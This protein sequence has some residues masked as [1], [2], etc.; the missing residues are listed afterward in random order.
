MT[1]ANLTMSQTANAMKE[2]QEQM[3]AARKDLA[4]QV[5]A[6][7]KTVLDLTTKAAI[8]SDVDEF[9]TPNSNYL[10]AVA[11]SAVWRALR[12]QLVSA[13]VRNEAVQADRA[14]LSQRMSEN[15]FRSDVERAGAERSLSYFEVLEERLQETE[16]LLT[17]YKHI[18]DSACAL[19]VT[20]DDDR[21]S[22]IPKDER[23]YV[24]M[25]QLRWVSNADKNANPTSWEDDDDIRRLADRA[26][27]A[28]QFLN[29]SGS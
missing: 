5:A 8:E 18:Y 27:F 19:Q 28:I 23:K 9:A 2:M 7:V 16:H 24:T 21:Q 20:E 11:A 17:V 13:H 3:D 10:T 29:G 14:I 4:K 25:P 26:E 22:D 12:D 6:D 15:S 1:T